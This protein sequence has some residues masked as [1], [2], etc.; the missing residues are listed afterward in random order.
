L[1]LRCLESNPLGTKCFTSGILN[2][3]GD[4]FAQ[5]MFEV[6]PPYSP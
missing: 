4:L 6:R 5:F 1:Y 3:A 2:A